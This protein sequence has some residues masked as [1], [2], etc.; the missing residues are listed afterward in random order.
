MN[1]Y[2]NPFIKLLKWRDNYYCFDVNRNQLLKIPHSTFQELQ[3]VQKGIGSNE[4]TEVAS[5]INL[6]FLSEKR[7]KVIEHPQ[8]AD[9][10]YLLNNK[11]SQITLQIMLNDLIQTNI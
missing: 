11:L 7:V 1:K 9:V 4:S 10:D 5:L 6:G 8:T 3:K 2:K